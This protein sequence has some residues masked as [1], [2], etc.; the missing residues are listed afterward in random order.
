VCA[1]LCSAEARPE[2][3]SASTAAP[4]QGQQSAAGM[5][6][7]ATRGLKGGNVECSS[8][9]EV[10]D[11][12]RGAAAAAQPAAGLP[13]PHSAGA[14]SPKRLCVCVCVCE[15][16]RATTGGA[17]SGS[18]VQSRSAPAC[19]CRRRPCC[20]CCCCCCCERTLKGNQRVVAQPGTQD[21]C[22]PLPPRH[23]P[24]HPHLC[25]RPS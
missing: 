1:A 18:T 6:T 4:V 5:S 7:A 8:A 25:R 10:H 9:L 24:H 21:S 11:P 12:H 17:T 23:G 16:E 22:M 20:C 14:Y 19:C 3:V 13:W 15:R 2:R